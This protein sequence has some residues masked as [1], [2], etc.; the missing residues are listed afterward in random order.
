MKK[1]IKWIVWLVIIAAFLIWGSTQFTV[2]NTQEQTAVLESEKFDRVAYV[3]AI[4]ESQLIPAVRENSTELPIVLDAI[5]K[6]LESSAEYAKISVS[7]A[8]NFRVRG[9]GIVEAVDLT[10]KDGKATIRLD[11]YD[12]SIQVFL[13]VGPKISGES[14]RDGAGFIE[15]GHFKDQT[16]YGQV[17]KEINKRVGNEVFE[18]FD[19]ANM[20]GKKISFGGMFTILTTNQTKIN[21]DTVTISPV[22]VEE[23]E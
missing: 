8:Y 15:F 3:D 23:G 20:I 11:G 13:N 9:I 5:A 6:D 4:W 7:G 17:S 14:I 22:Y 1:K 19:W 12:G 21:L 10:K 2:V 16:E 18:K